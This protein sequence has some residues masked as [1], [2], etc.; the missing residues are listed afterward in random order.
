VTVCSKSIRGSGA[1]FII[2][3][4]ALSALLSV[5]PDKEAVSNEEL[6]PGMPKDVFRA[7]P[8]A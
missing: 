8:S 7:Q 1:S 2:D 5:L 6:V 3:F 4:T